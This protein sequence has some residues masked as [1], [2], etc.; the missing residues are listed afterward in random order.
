MIKAGISGKERETS[1]GAK[2][3]EFLPIRYIIRILGRP[4]ARP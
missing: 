1:K 2:L 3:A 4:R